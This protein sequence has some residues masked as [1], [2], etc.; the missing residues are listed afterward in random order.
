MAD[1]AMAHVAMAL[2]SYGLQTQTVRIQRQWSERQRIG[3]D[4][5]PA[6]PSVARLVLNDLR[7]QTG[8]LKDPTKQYRV[9]AFYGCDLCSYGP[10]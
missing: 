10:T 8:L 4:P 5:D 3:D 6:G 1:I 7:N 2:Y 9:M